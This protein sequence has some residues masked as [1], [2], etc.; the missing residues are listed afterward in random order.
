MK[1]YHQKYHIDELSPREMKERVPR[2]DK[3]K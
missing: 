1:A 3:T 2:K